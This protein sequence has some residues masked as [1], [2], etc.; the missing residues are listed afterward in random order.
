[1]S[2]QKKVHI[3]RIASVVAMVSMSAIAHAQEPTTAQRATAESLFADGKQLMAAGKIADACKAFAESQALDAGG[4]TLFALAFCHEQENRTASA[5]LEFKEALALARRDGRRDREVLAEEHIAAL[6]PRIA[7]IAV[8][9]PEAAPG[10]VI[11]LDGA[12]LVDAAWGTSIPLDPGP[13]T[14]EA[15]AP[16]RV[17]WS[18]G[19]TIAA[20]AESR[21]VDVP[22][23]IADTTNASATTAPEPAKGAPHAQRVVGYVTA[24]SGIALLGLGAAFGIRAV[25]M[26]NRSD[27]S[28]DRT[29]CDAAGWS[30]YDSARSSARVANVALGAGI[31]ALG[32]GV[33]LL[34]TSQRAAGSTAAREVRIAPALGTNGAG[35]AATT[36]F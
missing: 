17:T 29:T 30:E 4:G 18:L 13:H 22:R 11:R 12:P 32:V 21:M 35:I 34:V 16:G 31:L 19:V 27:T 3:A 36:T 33:V 25:V 23:L 5:W 9:V 15:S 24:G 10:L 1:M 26:K 20:A 7:H 28:C 2:A 14:I 6:E 8:R